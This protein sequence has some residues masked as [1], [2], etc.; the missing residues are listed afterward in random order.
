MSIDEM[1]SKLPEQRYG[2]RWLTRDEGLN[3]PDPVSNHAPAAFVADVE[4]LKRIY[5]RFRRAWAHNGYIV[6]GVIGQTDKQVYF[7]ESNNEEIKQG[8][9][10]PDGLY[11]INDQVLYV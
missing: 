2:L 10:N 4:E 7:F 8:V 11:Y 3:F 5:I 6:M 1:F 9:L